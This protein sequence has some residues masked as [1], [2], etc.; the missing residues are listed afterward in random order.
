MKRSEVAGLK[1]VSVGTN[2]FQVMLLDVDVTHKFRI[3]QFI[4]RNTKSYLACSYG[5]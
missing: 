3:S 5:Y 4:E 2:I 1:L